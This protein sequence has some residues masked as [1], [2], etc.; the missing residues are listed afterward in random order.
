MTVRVRL[1]AAL[2]E[3]AGTDTTEARAG[4]VSE[5]LAELAARFG[6]PFATRAAVA[7]V[8]VDGQPARGSDPVADGAEVVLL[9]PVSGG[10]GEQTLPRPALGPA[11]LGAAGVPLVLLAGL[12][13]GPGW[14]AAAVV[15]VAVAVAVD[16]TEVLAA[17]SARPVVV[18]AALPAVGL[19]A[20]AALRPGIGWEAI[21]V[22]V[23][24]AL[25]LASAA[26]LVAGRRRRVVAALGAT[27]TVGLV[28]GLG[29][30]GV[31]LLAALPGGFRWLLA[32]L[33]LVTVADLG[34]VVAGTALDGQ[35]VIG[36]VLGAAAGGAVTTI[37]LSPP[38]APA[39][40]AML[41]VA[42]LVGAVGGTEARRALMTEAGQDPD[43]ADWRPGAGGILG[44]ADGIL[45]AAPVAYLVGRA[46]GL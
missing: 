3:A 41:V 37:A 5:V 40:T 38:L 23:A 24:A 29:A 25:L 20:A 28:V 36:A 27:V 34:W 10:A 42:V 12:L 35:P 39:S 21:P 46:A 9:P 11:A 33:V 31:V 44:A 7:S 2:R 22:W 26:V 19:P 18:A 32:I 8:L 6:E 16:L 1:F 45:L 15:A 4:S 13:A 30:V 14:L 17:T 43:Q